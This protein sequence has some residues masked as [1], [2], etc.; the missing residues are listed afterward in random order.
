MKMDER[1]SLLATGEATAWETFVAGWHLAYSARARR[2]LIR[3]TEV[4]ALL[5]QALVDTDDEI[6]IRPKPPKAGNLTPFLLGALLITLGWLVSTEW[7][8]YI[9]PTLVSWGI[10]AVKG[11]CATKAN[12]H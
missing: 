8:P 11:K 12:S 9:Q 5:K 10:G 3:Y 6:I 1:I 4:S 7:R 2:K